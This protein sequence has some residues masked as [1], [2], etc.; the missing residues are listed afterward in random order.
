MADERRCLQCRR[1]RLT[2]E[3]D[4]STWSC[5]TCP[6]RCST[7]KQYRSADAF[8]GR[9]TCTSCRNRLR[10]TYRAE[11]GKTLEDR[12]RWLK[13]A[14]KVVDEALRNRLKLEKEKARWHEDRERWLQGDTT[15]WAQQ[16]VAFKRGV[17]LKGPYRQWEGYTEPRELP[18]RAY[19]SWDTP[20]E[21]WRA[22]KPRFLLPEE[23][24]EVN[25]PQKEPQK[26]KELRGKL[27]EVDD[28]Y[29]VYIR[30][31]GWKVYW[32]KLQKRPQEEPH[33]RPQEESQ[34]RPQEANGPPGKPQEA[35]SSQEEPQELEDE[36]EVFVRGITPPE[37]YWEDPDGA[38]VLSRPRLPS[39]VVDEEALR[40]NREAWWLAAM[41]ERALDSWKEGEDESEGEGESEEDLD[42]QPIY[43][44]R[45]RF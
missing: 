33:E 29:E 12:A 36:Y 8:S 37:E 41:R 22:W 34:E 26:E 5:F 20:E 30:E 27:Q 19:E 14:R 44:K 4:P 15:F 2:S 1:V 13:Q 43:K 21:G 42:R 9:K 10:D 18:A 39:P 32:P 38:Q 6:I 11:K 24:R 40:K 35:N 17:F 7:C 23:P 25:G 28:K 16:T 45:K 31:G 3:M